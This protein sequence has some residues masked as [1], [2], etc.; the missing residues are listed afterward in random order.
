MLYGFECW[1]MINQ[2][3]IETNSILDNLRVAPLDDKVKTV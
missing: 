1:T 3:G 2:F